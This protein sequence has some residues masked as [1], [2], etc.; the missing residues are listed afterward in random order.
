MDK[1]QRARVLGELA[2]AELFLAQGAQNLADQEKR[3]ANLRRSGHDIERHEILLETFRE[4]YAQQL[5][6]RDLLVRELSE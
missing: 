3:V 5:S 2:D 6:H 1:A 4:T